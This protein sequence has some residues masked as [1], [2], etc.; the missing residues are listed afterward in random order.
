MKCLRALL[1]DALETFF[2]AMKVFFANIPYDISARAPEETYQAIFCAILYFIGVGVTP[3]VRTNEGRI[4]AVMEAPDHVYV[5]EFKRDRSASAL[6]AVAAVPN[7]H[8]LFGLVS[9]VF[10]GRFAVDTL[11]TERAGDFAFS[12][13]VI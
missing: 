4:D 12:M 9:G 2:G 10:V 6:C 1:A 7:V 8:F 11:C 13:M 5:M 3:E